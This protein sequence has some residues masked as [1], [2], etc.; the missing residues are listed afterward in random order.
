M[1]WAAPKKGKVSGIAVSYADRGGCLVGMIQMGHVS[2]AQAEGGQIA[3]R[4]QP[5]AVG[6]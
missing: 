5:P 4:L 1:G 2:F 6:T 3:R